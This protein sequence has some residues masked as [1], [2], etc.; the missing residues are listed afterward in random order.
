M[1]QEIHVEKNFHTDI[2]GLGQTATENLSLIEQVGNVEWK[3]KPPSN[4]DLSPH[5]RLGETLR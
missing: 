2:F 1:N 4:G 3:G 5:P